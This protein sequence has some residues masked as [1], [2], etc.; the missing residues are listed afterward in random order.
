MHK[1]LYRLLILEF[2]LIS[3]T[4]FAGCG[5]GGGGGPSPLEQIS[6][7]V[8]TNPAAIMKFI[9]QIPAV[10]ATIPTIQIQ[11][12]PASVANKVKISVPTPLPP[13][14]QVGKV[15]WV[16]GDFKAVYLPSMNATNKKARP[17]QNNSVIFQY[18]LL[19]TGPNSQAEIVFSDHSIMTL[20]DNTSIYIKK[21][22]FNPTANQ[23]SV[24]SDILNLIEG[25][26]RTITGLIPKTNPSDYKVYTDVATMGVRGTDYA[27]FFK[28]CKLLMKFNHGTPVLENQKG[29]LVLTSTTPFASAELNQAPVV[30]KVQPAV[31]KTQ[32]PITPAEFKP[33]VLTPLIINNLISGTKDQG[34]GGG[35][36]GGA[37]APGASGGGFEIKL[38]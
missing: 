23:G 21:F 18:D 25:G 20:R 12:G 35:G 24:G 17:L 8:H 26:F 34:F 10:S 15:V 22:E 30:L 7:L 36:G 4:T 16:K 14:V 38:R 31:F 27:A 5:G 6:N 9:P 19:V 11:P 37:C 3:Q 29:S 2:I 33:Q 32:L 28:G 1:L 13:P